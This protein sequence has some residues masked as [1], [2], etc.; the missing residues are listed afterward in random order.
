MFSY[1]IIKDS[2]FTSLDLKD[3]R[4][5]FNKLGEGEKKAKM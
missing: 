3:T 5:N 1:T 4:T 2:V